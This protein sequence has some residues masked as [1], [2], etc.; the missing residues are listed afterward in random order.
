MTYSE[1]KL[2]GAGIFHVFFG[3]DGILAGE[4]LDECMALVLV[5][6]ASLNGAEASKYSSELRFGAS[7]CIVLEYGM[8]M[9]SIAQNWQRLGLVG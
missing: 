9:E 7:T 1:G 2:A 4:H 5:D 3:I 6:D 8:A